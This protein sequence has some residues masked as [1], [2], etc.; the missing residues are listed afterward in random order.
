MAWDACQNAKCDPNNNGLA[1]PCKLKIGLK[2]D[3]MKG[4]KALML[5]PINLP[6]KVAKLVSAMLYWVE[7]LL[8]NSRKIETQQLHLSTTTTLVAQTLS[9]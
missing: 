1:S 6:F 8:I 2:L 7:F 3:E 5:L 9:K 4:E